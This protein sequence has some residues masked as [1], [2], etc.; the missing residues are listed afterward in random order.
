MS[1]TEAEAYKEYFKGYIPFFFKIEWGDLEQGDYFKYS[2]IYAEYKGYRFSYI[3]TGSARSFRQGFVE[4]NSFIEEIKEKTSSRYRIALLIGEDADFNMKLLRELV[5]NINI[6]IQPINIIDL[7]LLVHYLFP[8]NVYPSVIKKWEDRG[9]LND[10]IKFWLE[11]FKFHDDSVKWNV[12]TM[13]LYLDIPFDSVDVPMS[14]DTAFDLYRKLLLFAL[15][16]GVYTQKQSINSC[17]RKY[18]FSV[19]RDV[20]VPIL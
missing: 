10:N 4:L 14:A 17:V 9:Q 7:K 15:K 13:G 6:D 16:N 2:A 19:N 3:P 18:Q 11:F 5:K 12:Y 8:V 20:T 1:D